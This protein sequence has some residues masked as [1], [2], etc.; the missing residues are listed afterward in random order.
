MALS[1]STDLKNYVL[2][3]RVVKQMAGTNGTGGSA[4]L[5]IYCGSRPTSADAATAATAGTLL[6]RIINMGWNGTFGATGGTAGLATTGYTGTA[7]T[8]G[9]ATWARMETFG[10]GLTGSAATYRVD[11]DVGTASSNTFVIN[12]PIITVGSMVTIVTN[13]ISMG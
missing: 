6:A 1:I 12:S 10:T 3:Q 11:G 9:T 4:V 13:N 8:T 5:N 2:N 7:L